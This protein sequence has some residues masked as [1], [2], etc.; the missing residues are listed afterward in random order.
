MIATNTGKLNIMIATHWHADEHGRPA[1][2]D[3]TV[4]L[5]PGEKIDLKMLGIEV[6]C[7]HPGCCCVCGHKK[8]CP[9][10]GPSIV[11]GVTD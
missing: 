11:Q 8:E 3:G 4:S 1:H 5:M 6:D 2:I 9:E 7:F 10:D